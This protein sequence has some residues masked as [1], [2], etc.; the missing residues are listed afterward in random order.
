MR[1]IRIVLTLLSAMLV[2]AIA[3]GA[4]AGVPEIDNANASVRL[5][6]K[7]A[8]TQVTCAGEDGTDYVTFRGRWIGTQAEMT[9]GFTDYN[10]SGSLTVRRVEWTINLRTLRGVLTGVAV[11]VSPEAGTTTYLGRLTLITE[12]KP[13]ADSPA[14]AR[15]WLAAST[16]T[17]GTADG[18]SVLANVEMKIDATFAA[19]GGFGDA[20][21]TLGTLDYSV[22]TVN[23]TC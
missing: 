10:L 11:L 6:A 8:F 23:Q 16:Y 1:R 21:G 15:G 18:G 17:N 22:A 20:F 12:G 2:G 4:A 13:N 19:S 5:T 14:L 9:P 3:A 7:P